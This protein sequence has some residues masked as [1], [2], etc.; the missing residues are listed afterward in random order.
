MDV[1]SR[2]NLALAYMASE[3]AGFTHPDRDIYSTGKSTQ[4]LSWK[5]S[6]REPFVSGLPFA[7]MEYH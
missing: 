4:C 6:P 7:F 5:N 1:D 2:S 3:G